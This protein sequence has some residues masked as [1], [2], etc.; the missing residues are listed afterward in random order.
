[1]R[2]RRFFD[3]ADMHEK[4]YGRSRLYASTQ[5]RHETGGVLSLFSSLSF[6]ISI[7][8]NVQRWSL[9]FQGLF[10]VKIR[11]VAQ[12]SND[13]STL[14]SSVSSKFDIY[15]SSLW[16]GECPRQRPLLLLVACGK[17]QPSSLRSLAGWAWC[18]HPL[19]GQGEKARKET[20]MTL[21]NDERIRCLH[22]DCWSAWCSQ[23]LITLF[24][25]F[26]IALA[27]EWF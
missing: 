22:N 13:L 25:F 12:G 3:T 21:T 24:H 27:W 16:P 20:N 18:G 19:D 9:D 8:N 7:I 26:L 17:Q 6:D 1:M 4:L 2:K 14:P 11:K 23:R 10:R 15:F 5:G